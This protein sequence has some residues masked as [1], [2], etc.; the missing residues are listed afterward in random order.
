[1]KPK[2][3][4]RWCHRGLQWA[5]DRDEYGAVR[6][7]LI[8]YNEWAPCRFSSNWDMAFN[9]HPAHEADHSQYPLPEGEE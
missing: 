2:W 4:G 3:L 7:S 5:Q 9:I 1:M 6:T 8:R